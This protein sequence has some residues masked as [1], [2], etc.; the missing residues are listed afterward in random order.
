VPVFA[1]VRMTVVAAAGAPQSRAAK[2][3]RRATRFMGDYL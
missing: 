3:R 2:L 1:E